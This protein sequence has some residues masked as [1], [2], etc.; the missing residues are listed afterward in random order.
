[1][2]TPTQAYGELSAPANR[3]KRLMDLGQPRIGIVA[4]KDLRGDWPHE[5][6]KATERRGTGY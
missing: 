5:A 2:R 4:L 3:L 1:M 6:R